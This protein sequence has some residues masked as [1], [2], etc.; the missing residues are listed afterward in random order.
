MDKAMRD[1][2]A[3]NA[4]CEYKMK[5]QHGLNCVCIARCSQEPRWQ[6][7]G[8]IESIGIG[9]IE[10]S[11]KSLGGQGLWASCDS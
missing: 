3:G 5:C 7:I 1:S 9:S 8:H 4:V 10:R 2:S 11:T 6:C